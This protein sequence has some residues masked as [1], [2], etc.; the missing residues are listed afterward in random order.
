[1]TDHRPRILCL[2]GGGTNT[3]IFQYQARNLISKLKPHFRLVYANAPFLCDAGP[4]VL[5]LYR[6]HGPFRCWLPWKKALASDNDDDEPDKKAVIAAIEE[7]LERAM[8]ADHAGTGPWVGLVGFSQGAKLSASLL[9]EQELRRDQRRQTPPLSSSSSPSSCYQDWKFAVLLHGIA[10]LVALSEQGEEQEGMQR[11]DQILGLFS[12]G[13]Q[14]QEGKVSRPVTVP[15][16]HVHGLRDMGLPLSRKLLDVYCE[17]G[18]ATL[19]EWDGDHRVPVKT[20][21]V[22]RIVNEVFRVSGLA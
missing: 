1:M 13:F 4:N 17:S 19:I 2:H 18:S 3:I 6:D 15:T 10:P 8:R 16:I 11:A 21:D 5:P 7:S 22:Q 14:F 12:E 20:V 9:L